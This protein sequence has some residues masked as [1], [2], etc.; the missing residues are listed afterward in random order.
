MDLYKE[1]LIG[2]L[3][4]GEI[5]VNFSLQC[6]D[7]AHAIESECYQTLQ[8]IKA[9]IHDDTLTDRECFMK[10]EAIICALEEIGSNGG[11]RHDF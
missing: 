8:S 7:L 6:S 11:S 10:I 5:E 9:I 1:I 3:Q 4:R 2:I